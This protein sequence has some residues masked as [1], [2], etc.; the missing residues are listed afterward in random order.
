[1]A[2][3]YIVKRK[4]NEACVK[5]IASRHVNEDKEVCGVIE[6]EA[7]TKA[8]SNVPWLDIIYLPGGA[9]ALAEFTRGGQEQADNTTNKGKEVPTQDG[10][11]SSTSNAQKDGLA[12]SG[13]APPRPAEQ[14]KKDYSERLLD[15]CFKDVKTAESFLWIC[16]I[17]RESLE[18]PENGIGPPAATEALRAKLVGHL[19]CSGLEGLA[20]AARDGNINLMEGLILYKHF[21][22]NLMT[23]YAAV[24][25]LKQRQGE[26]LSSYT[27][28]AIGLWQGIRRVALV[29]RRTVDEECKIP[30]IRAPRLW[31][32]GIRQTNLEGFRKRGIEM[33]WFDPADASTLKDLCDKAED[34]LATEELYESPPKPKP[35][36]TPAKNGPYR[37]VA[38]ITPP[39]RTE[40]I[41]HGER[42][43]VRREPRYRTTPEQQGEES[44][45]C[46]SCSNGT[47]TW[48]RGCSNL[49]CDSRLRRCRFC[50]QR[51]FM[52]NRGCSTVGCGP[53]NAPAKSS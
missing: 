12:A 5:S 14:S 17:I 48:K 6:W 19:Q 15:S 40:N 23:A 43:N 34:W 38:A 16:P 8:N 11:S 3:I 45:P 1:M 53:G 37:A 49:A 2:S 21:G 22:Y 24:R 18:F 36:S 32:I 4:G 13:P 52:P 42:Q 35:S 25:A 33:K 50:L 28:R 29:D 20:K 44:A 7:K 9:E 47:V 31:V 26:P 51:T 41:S 39:A 46:L 10:E 30:E 27:R